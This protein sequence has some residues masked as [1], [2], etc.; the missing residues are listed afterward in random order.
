MIQ[1]W[2]NHFEFYTVYVIFM[3]YCGV[4]CLAGDLTDRRPDGKRNPFAFFR[5]ALTTYTSTYGRVSSIRSCDWRTRYHL[6]LIVCDF[7]TIRGCFEVFIGFIMSSYPWGLVMWFVQQTDTC[8]TSLASWQYTIVVKQVV[9][10]HDYTLV[11]HWITFN[12]SSQWLHFRQ[13]S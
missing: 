7:P 4:R 1:T 2:E 8:G 12:C 11:P 3:I 5:C 9:D 6:V 13:I 10:N